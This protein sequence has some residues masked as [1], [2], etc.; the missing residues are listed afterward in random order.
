MRRMNTL[1]LC[2]GH[3]VDFCR[4]DDAFITSNP[5]RKHGI[6]SDEYPGLRSGSH[7]GLPPL[8][9]H[10]ILTSRPSRKRG[11]ASDGHPG[12]LSGSRTNTRSEASWDRA[13]TLGFCLDRE[14]TPGRKHDGVG[15]TPW[16]SVWIKP[17]RKRGIAWI[18]PKTSKPGRKRGT[19][20]NE[21]LGLLLESRR[22]LQTPTGIVDFRHSR[23]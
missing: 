19:A 13:N 5:S 7:R 6:A 17:S 21:H 23:A 15:R 9:R 2:L 14:R 4:S 12:L 1:G 20:S 10:S 8:G 3:I 11:I 22:G 18:P 16:A